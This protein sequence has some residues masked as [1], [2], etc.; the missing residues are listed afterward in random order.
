M[1]P[2]VPEVGRPYYRAAS[3]LDA[4]AILEG[5]PDDEPPAP[6]GSNALRKWRRG[7]LNPRPDVIH[8]GFYVRSLVF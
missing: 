7:E 2:V 6:A 4:L 1:E 3:T 5:D 8:C